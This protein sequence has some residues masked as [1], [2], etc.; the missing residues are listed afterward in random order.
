MELRSELKQQQQLI[1]KLLRD[2]TSVKMERDTLMSMH[3]AMGRRP[4]DVPSSI[5]APARRAAPK[6]D[7]VMPSV[8][9][10]VAVAPLGSGHSPSTDLKSSSTFV[11]SLAGDDLPAMPM[12]ARSELAFPPPFVSPPPPHSPGKSTAPPGPSPRSH[13]SDSWIDDLFQE[14]S[15]WGASMRPPPLAKDELDTFLMEFVRGGQLPQ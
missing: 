14:S 6:P 2:V 3:S 13:V 8:S 9:R 11:A 12:S 5:Y 7:Q 10:L 4:T 15:M 1:S